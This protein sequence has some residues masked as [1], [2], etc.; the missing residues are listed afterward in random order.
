VVAAA[1]SLYLSNLLGQT[2]IAWATVFVVAT[3]SAYIF[4][5]VILRATDPIPRIDL[6]PLLA[7]SVLCAV[8]PLLPRTLAPLLSAAGAIALALA[9]RRLV[10]SNLRDLIVAASGIPL[11]VSGFVAG[12]G[13]AFAGTTAWTFGLLAVV[14]WPAAV[15]AE[16]VRQRRATLVIQGELTKAERHLEGADYAQSVKDFDR[17]I[18]LSGRGT[19]GEEMP[20]YGKGASLVLLGRYE[21]ALRA[22]D[23]ALD[24]NPRN[25]VAWLNKGNALTKMGRLLDALRCFNAAIKVNPKYEV[26]WN[27]KLRD[28]TPGV[29]PPGFE[30]MRGAW[31]AK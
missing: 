9:T 16:G 25:E 21:E 15:A 26:A 12:L 11:G 30:W 18:A 5:S 29:F 31:K 8:A 24:L 27:N 19:P 14:P 28:F 7:G 10:K 22:I 3:L 20:W 2:N 4:A 13:L 6:L 1:A 23:R 17:A